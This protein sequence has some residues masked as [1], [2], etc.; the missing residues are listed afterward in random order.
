MEFEQFKIRS[1]VEQELGQVVFRFLKGLDQ[2][3]AEKVDL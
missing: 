1:R 2:N 3:M